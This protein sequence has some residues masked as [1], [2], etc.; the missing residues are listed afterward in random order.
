MGREGGGLPKTRREE[1]VVQ[2][3]VWK[4]VGTRVGGL[5]QSLACA[6]L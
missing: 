6:A 1:S 3:N 2:L 4:L 5:F